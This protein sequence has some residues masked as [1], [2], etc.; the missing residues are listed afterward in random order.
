M[1]ARA[2]LIGGATGWLRPTALAAGLAAWVKV[3]A[4]G[5]VCATPWQGMC[6]AALTCR[7]P[8]RAACLGWP[9]HAARPCLW[10]HP[11]S[12]V[13]AGV[14]LACPAAVVASAGACP[15]D[16]VAQGESEALAEFVAQHSE[17]ALFL[18]HLSLLVM[19][20]RYRQ[21]N[22]AGGFMRPQR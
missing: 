21:A 16:V 2:L 18:V 8:P 15:H 22:P 13:C 1:L 17:A 9:A 3:T 10:A 7:P 19:N 11:G 4:A 5:R 6:A 20:H 12:P 14:G